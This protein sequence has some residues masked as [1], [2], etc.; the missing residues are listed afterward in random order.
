MEKISILIADDHK[1]IRQGI[2]NFLQ[3]QGEFEVKGEA[4]NGEEVIL[5]AKK[6]KPDVILMDL[7]MPKVDGIEAT[8]QI[9]QSLP[10]IKII[11][12]TAFTQNEKV[13]PAINSGVDGYLLKD[14]MPDELIAAI[15][16]VLN[17][18]PALHPDIVR[19]MML[20]M[21]TKDDQIRKT[22]K[23]TA[24]EI[25]VLNLLAE[26]KSNDDIAKALF[27][28]VLTVKTHVHNILNKMN[29]T[30]RVQAA[31]FAASQPEILDSGKFSEDTEDKD[32]T[33]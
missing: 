27:I 13:F 16:S 15:H 6:L 26:G 2:I 31:L 3:V 23:L 22:E 1:L 21:A 32:S 10:D 29:M 4:S 28:S 19:K 33:G 25:E 5:L 14:I 7:N 11:V 17:G 24:R 9:K 20:G 30:K 18:K 12:L 8:R